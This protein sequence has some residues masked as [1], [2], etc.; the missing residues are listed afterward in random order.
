MRY[1]E[2]IEVYRREIKN[3]VNTDSKII[4]EDVFLF[5]CFFKPYW[6]F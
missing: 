2:G 4:L 5:R 6:K 3:E 1:E